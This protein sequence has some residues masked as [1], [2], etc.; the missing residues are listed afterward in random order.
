MSYF[1][2][3]TWYCVYMLRSKK[4]GSIYIG[5]TSRLNKR[6]EEH[7]KGLNYTTKKLLPIELIY[8]EA[9]R[10]KDD[11]YRREKRLKQYGSAIR[12]LKSRLSDTLYRRRELG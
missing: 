6:L 10:S 3:E 11:A 2:H 1:P 7:R 9:Y 5:C 8:F 12:N 4:N